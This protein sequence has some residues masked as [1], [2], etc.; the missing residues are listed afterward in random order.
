MLYISKRSVISKLGTVVLYQNVTVAVGIYD[1]SIETHQ[2]IPSF[3]FEY[4]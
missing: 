2:I 1:N 4:R 3:V